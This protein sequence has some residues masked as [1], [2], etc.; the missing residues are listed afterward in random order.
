MTRIEQARNAYHRGQ[1]SIDVEYNR[2]EADAPV[3]LMK[4]Y[5]DEDLTI[6]VI[7]IDL[8]LSI[9]EAKLVDSEGA[10]LVHQMNAISY[11]ELES[12]NLTSPN[13]PR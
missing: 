1:E 6:A 13:G 9:D 5:I 8:I 3:S 11:S 12:R 7:P 10:Q 2:Q 4:E